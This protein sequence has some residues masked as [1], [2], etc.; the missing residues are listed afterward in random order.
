MRENVEV[1]REQDWLQRK[2]FKIEITNL[3]FRYFTELGDE[4]S[5]IEF[6][7]LSQCF[8]VRILILILIF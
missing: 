6:L 7:V 2:I 4:T 8:Q 1:Q 5:A 3:L